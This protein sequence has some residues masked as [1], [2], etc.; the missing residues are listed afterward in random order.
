MEQQEQE[1]FRQFNG[2]VQREVPFCQAACPFRLEITDF[3]EKTER[4][5]F[6]AAY[7]TYRNAVAF[8]V[9]VSAL[10]HEPC[11]TDCP[12][13]LPKAGG[14]AIELRAL[15]RSVLAFAENREPHDYNVPKKH[16]RVAVIG[17]GVSGL[18]CALRLAAR[19]YEVEVFEAADR[20]GGHLWAIADG[21]PGAGGLTPEIFLAEIEQQ[22]MHEDWTLH[23]NT[24]IHDLQELVAEGFDAIYVATGEGG[25]RFGI[26][27]G[28]ESGLVIG[29]TACFGGGSLFGKNTIE[30]LADGLAHASAIQGFFKTKNAVLPETSRET[31][32]SIDPAR[33]STSVTGPAPDENGRFTSEEAQREAGRCLRCQCDAC[34]SYCDVVA[35]SGKW[36]LRIKDDVFLTLQP[37]TADLRPR[38]AK[39]LINTCTHC[40]LCDDVCPANI[41]MDKL[42]LEARKE[43]HKLSRMP[44]AFH[45]FWLRDMAFADSEDCAVVRAPEGTGTA[46]YAFFPGCQLGASEPR[47]VIEAY[48]ALLEKEPSVAMF[49]HCCGTPVKWAGDSEGH[50]EALSLLRTAWKNLGSPTLI[51][52]CPTCMNNFAE[53]LPE[54]EI[55]SLYEFLAGRGGLLPSGKTDGRLWSIF[56]PC[57]SAGKDGL[58]N[59]VREFAAAA[60]F[61]LVPLP[62]Q[63]T[64]TA[65]CSFG[66]HVA[67]ANPAYRDFVVERRISESDHP[68]ITYCINC[69]DIFRE[70]GKETI[71]ILDILFGKGADDSSAALPTVSA[72]REN[73]V[74]LK[75]QLLRE[76]WGEE[77]AA[78]MPVSPLQVTISPALRQKIS[79]EYILEEDI[80]RT[81]EFCE[82]TGRRIALV[83]KGTFSGYHKTG[84]IT[85]WVEYKKTGDREYE[86]VNLYSHRMEIELEA[87]WNGQKIDID[88]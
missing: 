13:A 49:L 54:I 41:D 33:L 32:V 23:L 3:I 68:Y 88:V 40:G 36:P 44:W 39:R 79:D 11:K 78:A 70:A 48:R 71:H 76:F 47:Y 17:A 86:L 85:H 27:P 45:D 87:V 29:S 74:Y 83:E 8:P 50:L 63:E 53:F 15:E 67:T 52:A 35:F 26:A 21:S 31:A 19:K 42:F 73:R 16:E 14:S 75:K 59:T 65:C 72:R 20:I 2:C 81:I 80:I 84:H 6:D 10:C 43:I 57:A 46:R 82:R 34:R 30:A 58:R 37:G 4:G 5:V 25:E 64:H 28:A 66:G 51:I 7:K 22:F 1:I 55:V 61:S 69:R 38:P 77:R 56:D 9:I 62:V 18:A 60:G 12:R 24:R